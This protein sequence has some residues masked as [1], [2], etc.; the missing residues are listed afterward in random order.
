MLPS[1]LCTVPWK[2][3]IVIAGEE[4]LI[5]AF[6]TLFWDTHMR[7]DVNVMFSGERI[8]WKMVL[9]PRCSSKLLFQGVAICDMVV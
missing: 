9:K 4:C 8:G 5:L 2:K 1:P 3:T 7:R 6:G